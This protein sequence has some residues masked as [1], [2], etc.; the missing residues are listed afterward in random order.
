MANFDPTRLIVQLQNTG[1]AIKDNPQYQLLYQMLKAM[2]AINS[3]QNASSSSSSSSTVIN[4]TIQQIMSSDEGGSEEPGYMMIGSAS[5]S[6]SSG[7]T[8][9]QVALRVSLG[10]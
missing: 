8:M 9:A 4:Q 7:I 1:L 10:I 3:Q 5:S 6:P 2:A